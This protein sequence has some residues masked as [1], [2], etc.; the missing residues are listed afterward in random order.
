MVRFYSIEKRGTKV[1]YLICGPF[2][3]KINFFFFLFF[4]FFFFFLRDR[5]LHILI[6]NLDR[7]VLV[8]FRLLLKS[9]QTFQR[10][11]MKENPYIIKITKIYPHNENK[12]KI[13]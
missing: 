5:D 1:V 3:L 4:F 11:E 2:I 9:T 7:E 10:L 12:L 13:I 8:C 6:C